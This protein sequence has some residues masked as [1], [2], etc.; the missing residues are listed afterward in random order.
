MSRCLRIST[1][2]KK[3]QNMDTFREKLKEAK[4]LSQVKL[5][6]HISS[7]HPVIG[8]YELDEV[9]TSTSSIKKILENVTFFMLV[10]FALSYTYLYLYYRKF[11]IE[12][13]TYID[14]SEVVFL[15]S[16]IIPWL[17]P[18]SAPLLMDYFLKISNNDHLS[19]IEILEKFS[20]VLGL[21]SLMLLLSK[22]LLSSFTLYKNFE[23]EILSLL[24][25]CLTWISLIYLI[26]KNKNDELFI[27]KL[28]SSFILTLTAIATLSL[29][30]GTYAT[31][32]AN[33]VKIGNKVIS[34]VSFNYNN[35]RITTNDSLIF[36]GNTKSTLFLYNSQTKSSY[37]FS[38]AQ[39]SNMVYSSN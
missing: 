15:T 12:I 39:V 27:N 1:T 36:I 2:N 34:D 32:K 14:Y 25:I 21:I 24:L 22:I 20:K 31:Q 29:A 18:L 11:N 4:G 16:N 23:P 13:S 35:D 19:K 8:K 38:L 7:Y 37:V 26:L 10:L 17:L 33:S 3:F 28:F 6:K 9:K 5:A 30:I